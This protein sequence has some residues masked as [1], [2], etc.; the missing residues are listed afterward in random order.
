MTALQL[1]IAAGT[2]AN[3]GV[4]PVTKKEVFDATL[5]PKITAMIAAV[6]SMN[7]P[8]TGCTLPVFLPRQV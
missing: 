6:G 2:I 8:A 5:A 7:I 3:G 4:N 1:S